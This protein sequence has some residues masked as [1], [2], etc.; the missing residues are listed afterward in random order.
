MYLYTHILHI[1]IYTYKYM[2][3][4]M[5]I[6]SYYIKIQF[7]GPIYAIANDQGYKAYI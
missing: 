7:M 2:P 6:Y 3:T 5:H 4:N 1:L